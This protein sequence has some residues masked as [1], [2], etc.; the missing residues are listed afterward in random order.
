M[1]P[2]SE[3]WKIPESNS[4]W[5]FLASICFSV[6]LCCEVKWSTSFDD[7]WLTIM[8]HSQAKLK[9]FMRSNLRNGRK[10]K[11]FLSSSKRHSY[12]FCISELRRKTVT[13]CTYEDCWCFFPRNLNFLFSRCRFFYVEYEKLW[14]KICYLLSML[15]QKPND[16]AMC[17]SGILAPFTVAATWGVLVDV[18]SVI[19]CRNSFIA[20]A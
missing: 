7:G 15:I 11:A 2:S 13:C 18:I 8:I 10:K 16:V 3:K 20:V 14:F 12:F 19:T 6:A 17:L 9:H 5:I 1:Y 4:A